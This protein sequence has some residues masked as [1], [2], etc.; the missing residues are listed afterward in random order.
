MLDVICE[1]MEGDLIF[2]NFVEFDTLYGHKRDVA[3]W[4]MTLEEFD[5]KLP[6][7][8]SILMKKIY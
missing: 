1:S 4:C 7:L 3:G 6:K 5:K 2:A 8:F